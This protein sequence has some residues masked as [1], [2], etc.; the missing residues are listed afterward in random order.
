MKLMQDKS[1]NIEMFKKIFIIEFKIP[2]KGLQTFF[3][4]RN[5]NLTGVPNFE[6]VKLTL[7]DNK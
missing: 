5:L 7:K 6:K 4:Y 3:I 1:K 2:M